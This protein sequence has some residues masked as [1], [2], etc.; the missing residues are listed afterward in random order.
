MSII[1]KCSVN[2]NHYC[3]E[4]IKGALIRLKRELKKVTCTE[5]DMLA[6]KC[7]YEQI[8]FISEDKVIEVIDE[9]FEEVLE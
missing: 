5:E 2:K 1:Q 3:S 9:A 4:M 7:L 6:G 8:G